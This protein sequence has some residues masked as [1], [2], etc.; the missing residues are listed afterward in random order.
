MSRKGSVALIV[1]KWLGRVDVLIET[2]SMIVV[3]QFM[4]LDFGK[5]QTVG[6]R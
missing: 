4:R 5:K 1:A 2:P 6:S 3:Y